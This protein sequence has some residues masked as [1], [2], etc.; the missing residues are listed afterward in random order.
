MRS[1][2]IVLVLLLSAG[3]ARASAMLKPGATFPA[4]ELTDH[5][6]A[7]VSSRDL[8]GKPYLLW[9]FPKAMTSGCTAEGDALRDHIDGFKAKGVEVLGVSFDTPEDNA[10]FVREQSFSFRLLSDA[11]HKLA[12]DVG[13]VYVQIQPYASR[14][15]YLVGADGK[16][17]KA[18]DS[19]TPASHAQQVLDDL[20]AT[21]VSS[22]PAAAPPA[23]GAAAP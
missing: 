11:D 10:K 13:A 4:W 14:V 21:P 22:A 16:V 7:K 23:K 3:P 6:G 19:V 1:I 2:L 9:F 12:N 5:T 20:A 17:V 8:A 18:Y 15:S